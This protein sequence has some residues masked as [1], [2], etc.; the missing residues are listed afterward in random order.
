MLILM[1]TAPACENNTDEMYQFTG[2]VLCVYIC[3]NKTK[4]RNNKQSTNKKQTKQNNKPMNE[5]TNELYWVN[6]YIIC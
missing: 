4:S 5:R 2:I 1:N 3:F 6:C